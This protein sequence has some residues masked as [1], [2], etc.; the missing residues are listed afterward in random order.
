MNCFWGHTQ[1][2][3]EMG[4]V[5]LTWEGG[6]GSGGGQPGAVPSWDVSVGTVP[7]AS[8]ALCTSSVPGSISALTTLL[9][10]RLSALC[11]CETSHLAT[12]GPVGP[13]LQERACPVSPGG[14]D[15]HKQRPQSGH[16]AGVLVNA[17]E[18]AER[19]PCGEAVAGS[20]QT[21]SSAG[22]APPSAR[23]SCLGFVSPP[24]RETQN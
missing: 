10:A 1:Q 2:L 15:S 9:G 21:H 12:E 17:L 6:Q 5:L 24:W 4:R 18:Q 19:F 16:V 13:P 23:R 14:V 22:L 11:T 3:S 20:E 7:S 8:Q